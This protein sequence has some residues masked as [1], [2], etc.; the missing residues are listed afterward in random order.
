MNKKIV[1]LIVVIFFFIMF[2][3]FFCREVNWFNSQ[4]RLLSLKEPPG[5][6]IARILDPVCRQF[7]FL[8]GF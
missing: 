3:A 7:K 5:N 1:I 4:P 2:L 8:N 6:R